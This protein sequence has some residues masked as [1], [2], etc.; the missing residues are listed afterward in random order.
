MLKI[1]GRRNSFNVQKVMW[2]VNELELAHEHI[3]LGGKFG[4]LDTPEFLARNPCGHIPIIEDNDTIV[5]E[6]HTIL[7]YLAASYSKNKFWSD[8][9]VERSLT[10]RWMDWS[11][12]TLQPDFLN[13]VFWGFYRTPES[14]RNW[15]AIRNCITR[16]ARHFQ[17]LD[18]ILEGKQFL[19]GKELSL[20][21]IPAGAALYRYFELEIE[22]PKVPNVESWYKRLQERQAYRENVMIPFSD[23]KGCLNY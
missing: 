20:A 18:H 7:R 16:C 9:P 23:M 5:W 8:S 1:W 14:Q 12:A 21:D 3:P 22:R 13:G 15:P 6:S 19:C 17:L 11:Q 10:E 4:G 2:L